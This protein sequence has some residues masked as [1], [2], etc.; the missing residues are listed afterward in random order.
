MLKARLEAASRAEPSWGSRR[1]CEAVNDGLDGPRLGL[2]F[3]KALGRRLVRRLGWLVELYSYFFFFT[4]FTT[5]T[6]ISTENIWP[7]TFLKGIGHV[8]IVIYAGYHHTTWWQCTTRWQ[9]TMR[10]RTL[11]SAAECRMGKWGGSEQNGL[12]WV[13]TTRLGLR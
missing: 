4:L 10:R 9:H 7:A 12:K 13:Q 2:H 11:T 3:F 8:T 5:C 6:W 1:P